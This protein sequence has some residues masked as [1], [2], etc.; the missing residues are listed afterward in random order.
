M[1]FIKQEI[2]A[3]LKKKGYYP[4][5]STLW[6]SFEFKQIK[7]KNHQEITQNIQIIETNLQN[8]K[9]VYVDIL[10]QVVYIGKGK[11]IKKRI[12]S[13]YY[14]LI[15][16]NETN[17]RVAFVLNHQC[18]MNIYWL[19]IEDDNEREIVEH[20]LAYLLEPEYKKWRPI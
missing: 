3:L 11:P 8:Q 12:I 15:K 18:I 2:E 5:N 20:L 16:G 14:K 10:R 13:H 1:Y 17:N 7:P 6:N 9:G 19:E 4:L